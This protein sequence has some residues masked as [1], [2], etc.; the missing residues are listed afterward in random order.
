MI[1]DLFA[2]WNRVH[3]LHIPTH[4]QGYVYRVYPCVPCVCVRSVC[5]IIPRPCQPGGTYSHRG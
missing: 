2:V 5:I 4:F 3:T 1:N